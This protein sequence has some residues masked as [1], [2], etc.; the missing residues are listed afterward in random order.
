MPIDV[1]CQHKVDGSII[2]IKIKVRDEDGEF[3][4]FKIGAYRPLIEN[5]THLLPNGVPLNNHIWSYE[6]R[7]CMFGLEKITYLYYN[8][9]DGRW[10]CKMNRYEG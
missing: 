4:I 6:C 2:P 3:H 1:I 10:T 7:I 9:T 5:G 8:T